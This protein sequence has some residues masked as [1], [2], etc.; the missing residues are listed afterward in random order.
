MYRY[1]SYYFE[2]VILIAGG[3]GKGLSGKKHD[4]FYNSMAVIYF[5]GNEEEE[6]E[7]LGRE[8]QW[9][10][11]GTSP[12]AR[13]LLLFLIFLFFLYLCCLLSSP[14]PLPSLFPRCFIIIPCMF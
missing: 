11:P 7:V 1:K 8:Q 12:L 6:G 13:K 14:H 9:R 2:V 3:W 5:P 10:E 4:Y